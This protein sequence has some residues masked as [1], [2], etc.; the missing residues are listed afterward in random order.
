MGRWFRPWHLGLLIL[1]AAGAVTVVL[2]ASDRDPQETAS[3]R[4]TDGEVIVYRSPTCGCCAKWEDYIEGEGFSVRSE[5][6]EDTESVKDRHGVP[7]EAWSCHT[8]LVGDYV[9]EGHVPVE[10]I[11]KL[12]SEKPDIDGI[13]L[14]GMP[15]GSPGMGGTKNAPWEILSFKDG[16]TDT[17]VTI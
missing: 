10:V 13:A 3:A 8:A 12:L 16:A 7:P 2:L 6:V 17:Y 1:V 9:V 5:V 4:P 15:N 11:R 14:P